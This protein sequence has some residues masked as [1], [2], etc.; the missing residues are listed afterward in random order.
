MKI[1]GVDFNDKWVA[2]FQS[3]DEFAEAPQNAHLFPELKQVEQRKEQLKS[4]WSIIVKPV[5]PISHDSEP[6][7]DKPEKVKRARGNKKSLGG[8]Q[9]SDGT[10]ERDADGEGQRQ[11]EPADNLRGE[12]ELLGEDNEA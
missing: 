3:A 10:A 6:N 9:T 7:D 4:I 8:N 5:Q 1:N 11:Q 12:D 2:K